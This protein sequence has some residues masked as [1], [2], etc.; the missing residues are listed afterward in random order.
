MMN[1]SAM[2]CCCVCVCVCV[3]EPRD[4]QVMN[5]PVNELE[6]KWPLVIISQCEEEEETPREDASLYLGSSLPLSL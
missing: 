1:A 6:H 4:V 5:G 3:C 2:S